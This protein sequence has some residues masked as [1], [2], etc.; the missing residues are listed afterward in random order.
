MNKKVSLITAIFLSTLLLYGCT[1]NK[2]QENISVTETVE[3]KSENTYNDEI[4]F[5]K[6]QEGN[7][8]S[9]SIHKETYNYSNDKSS[10]VSILYPIVTI[11][12]NKELTDKI[13]EVIKKAAFNWYSEEEI[14]NEYNANI[15]I[16][17][18]IV[19]SSED[20]LSIYF[21]GEWIKGII[22]RGLSI[23]LKD[24][25][26]QTLDSFNISKE[27]LMDLL[28]SKNI[29]SSNKALIED[30]NDRNESIPDYIYN[31]YINYN[32]EEYN[33][34]IDDSSIYIVTTVAPVEGY[35]IT[36]K[37]AYDIE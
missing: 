35:S 17:Y 23:S 37:I 9:Y 11:N 28:K 27:D 25:S 26:I 4:S 10:N 12:N 7:F 20:T 19:Y 6:V 31:E 30:L 3:E 18:T 13:N 36:L 16:D 1:N 24:G 14:V 2:E 33:F 34:F 22:E 5:Q 32:D 21:S 15:N 8:S 29:A